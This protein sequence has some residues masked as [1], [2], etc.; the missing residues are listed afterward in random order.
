[1]PP[2]ARTSSSLPL[3][4]GPVCLAQQCVV[5]RVLEKKS[6]SCNF[7]SDSRVAAD[8]ATYTSRTGKGRM[9]LSG[10]ILFRVSFGMGMARF[11]WRANI[12]LWELFFPA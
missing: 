4:A 10:K 12:V 5:K 1:M 3:L 8:G 9:Y 2:A 6:S 11:P 7:R